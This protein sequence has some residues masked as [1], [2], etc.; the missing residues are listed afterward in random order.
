MS[1]RLTLDVWLDGSPIPAGSLT[2]HDDQSLGF[3]Y[4]EDYLAGTHPALSLALPLAAEP[5]ADALTRAFFGNLLPENDAMRRV[6]EREGLDRNDI[7]GILFHVGADCA[8]AISCLPEGS[9]P[10]KVPGVLEEDYRPLEEGELE[11]IVQSLADERRLPDDI[12]DP[13]PVA[14]VQRKIA[15]TM[16]ADGRFALP[17]EGRH[18]PTTHILKVPRRGKEEEAVLEEAAARLAGAVGLDVCVPEAQRIGDAEALLIERFDRV[19]VDGTVYRIHQEDFAQALGLPASL[20]YERRGQAGRRFDAAAIVS[21]LDRTTNPALARERFLLATLF[22]LAIGN[23]DN[24][25]KNHGLLYEGGTAPRLTPLYDLLPTRLDPDVTH[26]LAYRIGEAEELEAIRPD[27][28]EAFLDVFGISGARARRFIQTV[29]RPMMH[30][31]EEESAA[32][33]QAKLKKFD[34]LIGR[35]LA[36]LDEVFRLDL[37]LRE[38]DYFLA[39]GGGWLAS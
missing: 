4:A 27:D 13:S 20:K 30:R 19:V 3:A 37:E 28:I 33:G 16:L 36:Q 29:A 14:G 22:N 10:A 18:V 38:R 5:F 34:N 7:T 21:L 1:I 24:H 12:N 31:L 39:R 11:K 32:L 17:I 2:A 8:G 15:L 25:A 9:P 26:A 35:E 23:N 6:I